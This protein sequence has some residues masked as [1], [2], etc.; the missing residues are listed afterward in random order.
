MALII[1]SNRLPLTIR[2]GPSGP[3]L[4]ESPGGVATGLRGIAEASG[5]AWIG[6]PGPTDELTVQQR[7]E[8]DAT[9]RARG[10]VAVPLSRQEVRGYYQS[11]A[12]GV[13][14]PLFHY[15][16]QQV[17]LRPRHW[18]DYEKVNQRF[19]EVIAA[20][21]GPDD[22]VWI[23]DYQLMRVPAFLRRLRPSLRIGFFLHI[24]FPAYEVFRILPMRRPLL[25]GILG[26]DLIGFH[27]SSYVEHFAECVRRLLGIP[28]VEEGHFEY[29][30]RTPATGVFP[31]G[32]EV[33]RFEDVGA[34][35]P[36]G[37]D[38]RTPGTGTTGKTMVGIDRLDYTK[39]I[40]RR[41]LAFEQLLRSHPELRERVSFLQVAVPSRTGVRAYRRF[42]RHVDAMVGRI[43]GAYGSPGWTP[44]QYLYRGFTQSELLSLYRSADVM[45]VTPVRDGMNLVAKEFVAS[46]VDGDGV[47]VLSEFTGAATELVE[48]V[49]INP[50]DIEATADAYYLAL[51][52]PRHERRARMHALRSRVRAN[53]VERWAASFL[54]KLSAAPRGGAAPEMGFTAAGALREQMDRLVCASSVV[55]LLDYDGTL[56]PFAPTPD[57]ATPDSDLLGLLGALAVRPATRVHLVSGRQRENLEAW[58]GELAIGL[59]AEHGLWSRAPS[60]G[61]WQRHDIA[62]AVPYDQLLGLLKHFTDRTP[63]SSIE[64]KS[65]GLAWH[66]RLARPDLAAVHAEA[67]LEEVRRRFPSDTVEV[68]RGEKVLEFRPA[69]VHKGLIVTRIMQQSGPASTLVA[70][71][72]DATDEDMFAALP[73][74]GLSVHVGPRPSGATIRL[75]DVAA[76][77]EF[78]RGFLEPSPRSP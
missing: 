27:T 13:L 58:F 52:M 3:V 64:R 31:M 4:V 55:L 47:L 41:L 44:V 51:T 61:D 8:L 43:N 40:P 18:P 15:L 75:R 35:S 39:G 77:R 30:G 23:H 45:L 69:G 26:A 10:C 74:D 78:L 48:A 16:I 62:R 54:D 17:P 7:S 28:A 38:R 21:C 5:G 57:L 67:V 70:V 22:E 59:H 76:C 60:T 72:D 42:R 49:H 1:A 9:L 46:R 11:V 50:Y 68:L 2:P 6:W 73:P 36:F 19:A 53:P 34:E 24:P 33:S 37:G 56:V 14:W 66:F 32:V 71:G 65:A 25:E 29:E 12:N 20:S 63:G